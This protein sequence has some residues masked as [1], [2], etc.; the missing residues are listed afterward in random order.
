L[1]L[2]DISYTN[3]KLTDTTIGVSA[4]IPGTFSKV[5]LSL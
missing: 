5:F 2:A 1:V 3:V 4:D